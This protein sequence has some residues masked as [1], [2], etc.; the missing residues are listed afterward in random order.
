MLAESRR[1]GACSAQ[2][3]GC[4]CAVL[5]TARGWWYRVGGL[6][7]VFGFVQGSAEPGHGGAVGGIGDTESIP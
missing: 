2:A 3:L 1:G 6:C 7:E 4:S 5:G